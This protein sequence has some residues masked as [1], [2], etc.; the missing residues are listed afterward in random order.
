MSRVTTVLVTAG[1]VVAVAILGLQFALADTALGLVE[2]RAYY[3]LD[4]GVSGE[5]EN[6]S[7]RPGQRVLK[8]TLLATLKPQRYQAALDGSLAREVYL[9]QALEEARK[10]N[11]R[12]QI[13][14]DEGSMSVVDLDTSNLALSRAIAKQ[15][16]ASAERVAAESKLAMSRIIAPVSG[17][18][19]RRNVHPGERVI[20]H[21]RKQP[22][23]VMASSEVVIRLKLDPAV[24]R[25]PSGGAEVNVLIDGEILVGLVELVDLYSVAGKAVIT[26]TTERKLP[27]PG[28]QVEI[29]Y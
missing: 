13:L 20:R 16:K 19:V 26:V 29:D 27:A 17:L 10:T 3:S 7:V 23:F 9:E 12:D 5:V 8:E 21:N 18:I 25:L 15:A 24:Q 28:R 11:E 1:E 2:P 4:F 6:I 14:F 22:A